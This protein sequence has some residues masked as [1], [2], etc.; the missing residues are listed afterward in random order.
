MALSTGIQHIHY[1][2]I[3]KRKYHT[4]G[5]FPKPNRKFVEKG[6]KSI[7]YHGNCDKSHK[8]YNTKYIYSIYP[9]AGVAG[10]LLNNLFSTWYSWK[11][12]HLKININHRWSWI[13]PVRRCHSYDLISS[14][15]TNKS[16][17]SMVLWTGIQHIHYQ[18]IKKRKYNDEKEISMVICNVLHF[19]TWNPC[20]VRWLPH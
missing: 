17:I 14:L 10:M 3:K 2:H 8:L 18:H 4:V 9:R 1:Q 12:A 11:I 15:R 19:N 7:L 20:M 13:F 16:N 5:T 6:K